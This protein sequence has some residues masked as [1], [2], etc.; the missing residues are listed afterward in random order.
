MHLN[1]PVRD[2]GSFKNYITGL[3]ALMVGAFN[4]SAIDTR[5]ILDVYKKNLKRQILKLQKQDH[6]K[7]N[8]TKKEYHREETNFA[9]LP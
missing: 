6:S 7:K 5:L 9:T 4:H 2:K 1:V 3:H 8:E